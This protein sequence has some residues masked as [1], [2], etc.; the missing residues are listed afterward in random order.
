MKI[1]LGTLKNMFLNKKQYVSTGF[2]LLS[3]QQLEG[4]RGLLRRFVPHL[5][6]GFISRHGLEKSKLSVFIVNG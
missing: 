2:I 6:Q 1:D 5:L 4:G 3:E